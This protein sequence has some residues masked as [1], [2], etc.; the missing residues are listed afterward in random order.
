MTMVATST[1]NRQV[2]S[3]VSTIQQ[4]FQQRPHP[5]EEQGYAAPQRRVVKHTDNLQ[6]PTAGNQNMQMLQAT[7]HTTK[8]PVKQRCFNYGEKDHYAHVCPKLRPHPNWM[9]STNPSPGRVAN[10]VFMTTRHNLARGRVNQVVVE[11][12][13][14]A[15][16]NATHLINSYS[17]LIIP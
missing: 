1:P 8:D 6:T 5:T 11:E 9:P 12:V 7:P 16:M 10:S 3:T 13:Q 15:P 4:Q 2:N 14:D 17:I